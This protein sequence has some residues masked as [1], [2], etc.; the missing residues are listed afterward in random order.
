LAWA[1]AAE[2]GRAAIS[3]CVDWIPAIDADR[4]LRDGA[5]IAELTHLIDLSAY[6]EGTRMIVREE[7]PHPGAQLSV[8]DTIEARAT[9]C[10]S[11]T[12]HD[13]PAL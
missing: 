11:P 1:Q 5:E 7:R 8:F 2:T 9:R 10:S 3:A 13:Q 6:L 4:D 12:P